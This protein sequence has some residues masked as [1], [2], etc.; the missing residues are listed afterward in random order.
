MKLAPKR[1]AR[2]PVAALCLLL[3]SVASAA[4]ARDDARPARWASV[5]S[6]NFLLVGDAD[7]RDMLRVAARLEQFR[8]AFL[9]LLPVTH[10][11]SSVPLTVVVFRDDA[12]YARFE[13]VYDGRPAGVSGFFQSGPDVDYIALTLDPRRARH[14]DELAFHEYVHLLVRNGFGSVPLWFNEGLAEYYSTFDVEGGGRGVTLGRPVKY[15]VRTLKERELLPLETLFGVDDDSPYYK[16][17]EKR[18]IFYAQSW[19]LVHYLLSGPRR[20]QLSA[21]LELQGRGAKLEDAFRQAFQTDFAGLLGELRDYVRLGKYRPQEIAFDRR[22]DADPRALAGSLT[23][24]EE[25]FY[26]GDLLLHTNRVEEAASRLER[27]AALDPRLAVARAALAVLRARQN[28]FEGAAKLLDGDYGGGGGPARDRY[29]VHY[30]RAYALSRQGSASDTFVETFYGDAT[31]ARMRAELEKAI[32]LNPGFAE[33]YRLLAFV[34]LVRDERLD[35][36]LSLLKRA[37]E[38]SPRRREYPLL[39]A[40]IHLRR[41]EFEDTRRVLGP[42]AAGSGGGSPAMRS[43]AQRLLAAAAAREEYLARLRELDKKNAEAAAREEAPPAGVP[44][45]PCDAPQPGPQ[46]KKLRFSGQQACG[47]LVRFE[48]D[49]RGVLLVVE[50]EGRTLHLRSESTSDIRFVTYTTEVRGQ[51]TCG[52]RTPESPVLVTY[53]PARSPAASQ[54]DGVVVAVEFLPRE[55]NANH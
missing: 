29:L 3:A 35:E 12:S 21:F 46:L 20:A 8:A 9:R 26:L 6:E 14:A 33:A 1:F 52:E 32:A 28:D 54:A 31:A 45:Q 38:L 42:L 37:I 15:R 47:L 17:P 48:C 10:F 39:L 34:N 18:A 36:S 16:E 43:Q 30:Y 41:D 40:Q 22:L 24:A 4:G 7:G 13:P 44:L 53:R 49:E 19:A 51:V 2:L 11:D 5:R 55:W 25:E 50:S 23:E 27:A